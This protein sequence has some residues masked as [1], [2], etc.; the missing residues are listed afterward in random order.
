MPMIS[1]IHWSRSINPF[2][3]GGY[4][5]PL[6]ITLHTEMLR[7]VPLIEQSAIAA[8]REYG[9]L[10]G[11]VRIL[12]TEPTDYPHIEIGDP[13]EHMIPVQVKLNNEHKLD[14]YI[15][16]P[17]QWPNVAMRILNQTNPDDVTKDML[18]LIHITQAHKS[19]DGDIFVTLSPELLKY[20]SNRIFNELNIRTPLETI[21]IL[22]L[23]LRS[24]G[25]Y[26]M[27]VSKKPNMK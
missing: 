6:S 8:L 2:S 24:R 22:G 10:T 25:N 3:R 27:R 11:L 18:N 13:T 7:E 23:L 16:F 1:E 14:T 12:E 17:K 21:K 15:P 4:E 20:R 26:T 9:H 5:R 19:V